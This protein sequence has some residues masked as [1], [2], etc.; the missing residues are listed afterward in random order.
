MFARF[1]K[2]IDPFRDQPVEAPPAG[3]VAFCWYYTR[4]HWRA[5]ATVSVLGALIAIFE[6][7]V[8]SFLG[9]LVTWLTEADRATFFTDNA[10]HLAWMALVIVDLVVKYVCSCRPCY[11]CMWALLPLCGL[12][13][14]VLLML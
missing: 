8:F 1:E 6:V 7:M 13:V 10:W 5:M 3:L 2:L 4:P 9:D 11:R 12:H 14:G